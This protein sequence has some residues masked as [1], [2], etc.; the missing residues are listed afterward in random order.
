MTQNLSFHSFCDVPAQLIMSGSVL[1]I[2]YMSGCPSGLQCIS[3]AASCSV[4][5]HSALKRQAKV[6]AMASDCCS[7]SIYVLHLGQSKGQCLESSTRCPSLLINFR[8]CLLLK[9]PNGQAQ[10]TFNQVL[11]GDMTQCAFCLPSTKFSYCEYEQGQV[12]LDLWL[13]HRAFSHCHPSG[14]S[15]L[16]LAHAQAAPSW[17][18]TG[19]L[20]SLAL[21]S[22]TCSAA[23][24]P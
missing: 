20:Q 12:H 4:Q 19:P 11:P 5:P 15:A 18:H 7:S 23:A 3:P 10:G 13:T 2:A 16:A 24:G 8:H 14:C 17:L 22:S 21:C 9:G 6:Y 1:H